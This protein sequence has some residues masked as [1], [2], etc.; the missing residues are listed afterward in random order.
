MGAEGHCWPNA[1][2][3]Y[4]H[5]NPYAQGNPHALPDVDPVAY[6]HA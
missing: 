6:A 4:P 1:A 3:Q 5:P 2:N